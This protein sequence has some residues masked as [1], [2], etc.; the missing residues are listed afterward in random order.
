MLSPLSRKI[1]TELTP[2]KSSV[3][4]TVKVAVGLA[5]LKLTL[6]G[7]LRLVSVGGVVSAKFL[8][9][10]YQLATIERFD[11]QLPMIASL[12]P[13]EIDGTSWECAPG[14]I[15]GVSRNRH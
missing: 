14:R 4:S 11:T 13:D 7:K 5:T 6:V 3:A 9:L 2:D 12:T 1:T 8:A 15:V 10:C